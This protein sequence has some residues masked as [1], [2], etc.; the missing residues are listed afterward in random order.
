MKNI[1][2]LD[3]DSSILFL[4]KR[5]L[6][7]MGYHSLT[8]QSY[9][10]LDKYLSEA[11]SPPG[12]LFDLIISDVKM[13]EIDGIEVVNKLRAKDPTCNVLL[14]TSFSEPE[15]G[16]RAISAGALDYIEKPLMNPSNFEFLVEKWIE[17]TRGKPKA[18]LKSER[19]RIDP[20][21]ESFL[22]DS[23]YLKEITQV[24]QKVAHTTVN[25]LIHGE[26]GTGK[27]IIARYIHSKGS[28]T[29]PF[30]PINCSAIP[31]DLLES[32]LFGHEKGSFTGAH[33]TKQGLFEKAEG[34]TIFLDEIG[35][36]NLGLQAKLLRVIQE[37]KVRRIGGIEEIP[38]RAKVVS[39]THR[40]LNKMISENNF[41]KDLFYRLNVV[42]LE[43]P[44]L[45]ERVD[46][47]EQ[48]A[49]FLLRKLALKHNVETLP[50]GKEAIAQLYECK[51]PGNVREL[52]NV[53]ERSLL[54]SSEEKFIKRLDI[55][56]ATQG[57]SFQIRP[58]A[59]VNESQFSV[60]ADATLEEVELQ[61]IE[62]MLE[63]CH[64]NKSLTAKKLG[65]GLRTLYRK[66]DK[67]DPLKA[68]ATK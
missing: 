16:V 38:I 27:E 29:G 2:V 46:D 28:L 4:A 53:L 42:C 49:D 18:P 65:I 55:A 37:K 24:V 11:G 56:L 64:Y 8:F 62:F 35:D 26:T 60:S 33:H 66:L 21:S 41:R 48:L 47:L 50:L 1:A 31:A 7:S 54:V 52:E 15:D 40:D 59:M 57:P 45:R 63:K 68:L 23:K 34:G 12:E 13:P 9:F 39:A 61:Y 67:S 43:L 6:D 19:T 20:T 32:E 58:K 10:D 17:S 30:I 22:E 3:D 51:W 14:M 36:M 44:P 5:L 25:I